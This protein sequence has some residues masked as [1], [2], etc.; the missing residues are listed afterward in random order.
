MDAI[1]SQLNRVRGVGGCVLCSPD[2]LP[3]ASALR[4]DID[5]DTIAANIANL[6]SHAHRLSTR[7][8]LG[9][10]CM[11]HALAEDAGG[12]LLLAAGPG[13]LA[14]LTNPNA[15]L[16]LLQLETRPFAEAIAKRLSL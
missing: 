12:L 14:I 7:M 15:N 6:I 9:K 8:E 1:L 10:P 3:M 11:V 2:G 16:A 4:E 13:F 5:E